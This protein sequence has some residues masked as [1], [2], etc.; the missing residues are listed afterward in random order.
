MSPLRQLAADYLAMRRAAGYRL[1]QEGRM[2]TGFVSY[3]EE[4]GTGRVT[5]E[6]ALAWATKPAGADP[7]WHAARLSVVRGFARY[8]AAVD[9]RTEIPPSG[10]I[11]SR[12]RRAVPHLYSPGQ[13]TAVM[14]AARRLPS[15]LRAATFETLIGLMAV[16]GL[17]TGE[18]MS[19]DRGDVDPATGVLAVRCSK[20]GKDRQVPLHPTTAGALNR[21]TH[22]RDELCPH[23]SA[24]AFFLSGAGTRLNHTNTSKTFTRLLGDAGIPVPPGRHR[25][26]LYDLRHSF[27]VATLV[28][29]YAQGADVP[30]RLPAL[31]TYLGHVSPTK[32]SQTVFAGH[33]ARGVVFV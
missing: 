27:A 20:F 17:R 33:G 2:L 16:T 28:T 23:P 26:R 18:A 22:R 24:P 15:P 21:Y 4:C 8:L 10:L 7:G 3:L 14:G 13:I 25:P 19:L 11:A 12:E 30:A 1:R 32:G 6:A 29:W 9:G 5:T 31:S